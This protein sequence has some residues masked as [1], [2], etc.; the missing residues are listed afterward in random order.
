M[1]ELALKPESEQLETSSSVNAGVNV[2]KGPRQKIWIDLDNSPHVPFFA[3]IIEELERSGHKILLTARDCFQVCDLA[4]LLHLRY[5]RVG[6]HYGKNPVWKLAGLCRRALQLIP[7]VL[8]ERPVLALSHGS[9]SQLLVANLLRI[10]SVTI[11][12]YEFAKIWMLVRPTWVITPEIISDRNIHASKERILKYPGIKEDVYVPRFIPDPRIVATLGLDGNEVIVLV[13]PPATEAHYHRPESD[14]LFE[15]VL[16]FLRESSESK[17]IL[18]PRNERQATDIRSNWA[19]LFAT[20]QI[21]IPSSVVNGLD[22]IWYAD[23]VISGGGTMNR[24]AAALD[25]PVYSIF[26]GKIGAVDRYLAAEGRLTLIESRED[27][28]SKLILR[29]RNRPSGTQVRQDI[30]L[31]TIIQ[32]LTTILNER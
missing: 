17:I 12:D 15:G 24:E 20:G 10:P 26:R 27:I 32:H 5:L 13:R 8:R 14:E 18:L 21:V 25:V 29:K 28:R 22:L 23:L 2:H 19:A 1:S 9:R 30:T 6:R 16:S 31:A 7:Y 4:D 3:P 11:A